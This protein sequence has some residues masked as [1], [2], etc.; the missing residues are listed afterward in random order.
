MSPTLP[1][2]SEQPLAL[3]TSVTPDYLKVMEIPLLKGRFIDEH[4]RKDSE[5]VVVIDNVLAKKR[6]ATQTLSGSACG[7]PIPRAPFLQGLMDLMSCAWSASWGTCGT[8][9][10]RE[11]INRK[12]ARSFITH[13]HKSRMR[14][15]GAG[16]N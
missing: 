4:D 15:C 10:W 6:S 2:V 13:L 14:C 3:A 9:D 1:P 7:C 12:C 11:T 16:L 8:G 5:L